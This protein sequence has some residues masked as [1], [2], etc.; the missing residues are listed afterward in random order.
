V[1]LG[2][3]PEAL[4]PVLD[5]PGW[6]DL[7]VTGDAPLWTDSFSDLLGSFRWSAVG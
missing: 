2:R 4:A 7:D 5:A 3:T 6:S 1:V